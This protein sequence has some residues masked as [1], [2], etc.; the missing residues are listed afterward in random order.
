LAFFL[1]FSYYFAHGLL[2]TR[3][4]YLRDRHICL[5]LHFFGVRA[6]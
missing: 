2:A 4:S 1:T 6:I 5:C 3:F